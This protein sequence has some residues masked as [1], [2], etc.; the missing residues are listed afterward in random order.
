[1]TS[2]E[3]PSPEPFLKKQPYWGGDNSGNALEAS[4]ALNYRACGIPAVLSK[5]IPGKA[6]RSRKEQTHKHI[7]REENTP[8]PKI[9]ALLR[10]RP[11]LLRANLSLLRT[12]NGLTTDI[13]VV[14]CTGRGLVVKR[15]GVL[16]K[17]QMLNL[18]LGVGVFSLLPNINKFAGLSRD[19]VGGKNLFM[20]FLG[21]IPCGG[22]K[23]HKQNPPQNSGTIPWKLCLRVFFFMCFFCAPHE[24]VSAVF[25][26]FFRNFFRYWGYGPLN[27]R[28]RQGG[29]VTGTLYCHWGQGQRCSH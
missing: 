18:V 4:N 8:T 2:S 24:S 21:V 17:I 10:K 9:S 22:E 14:K 1:M 27:L 25:P 11:F 26:E 5:G 13:F 7:G 12:E 28:L 20:C 16:S 6:L 15:P 19:W 29:L 3:R 23:T